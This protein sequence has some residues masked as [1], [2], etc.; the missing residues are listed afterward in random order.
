MTFSVKE[1]VKKSDWKA[2]QFLKE[3]SM[4][5]IH[6]YF[7]GDWIYK[8]TRVIFWQQVLPS[9]LHQAH[10]FVHI[11][12]RIHEKRLDIFLYVL[13]QKMWN[14]VTVLV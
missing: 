13:I 11:I 12:G 3:I 2:I 10:V 4:K 9:D 8:P 1:K 5:E 7:G 14:F 6:Y